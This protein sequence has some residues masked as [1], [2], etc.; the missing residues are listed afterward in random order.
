MGVR[1][2]Q[3]ARLFAVMVLMTGALFGGCR[4]YRRPLYGEYRTCLGRSVMTGLSQRTDHGAKWGGSV[5]LLFG[6]NWNCI[7]KAGYSAGQK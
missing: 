6:S 7:S 1:Q 3:V 5:T 2:R 4:K